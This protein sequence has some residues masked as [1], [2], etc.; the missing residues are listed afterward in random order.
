MMSSSTLPLEYAAG[1]EVACNH[2]CGFGGWQWRPETTSDI[3]EEG[4]K[5]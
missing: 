3:K 5:G 1:V 2:S 4:G